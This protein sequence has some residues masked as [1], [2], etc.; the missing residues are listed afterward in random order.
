MSFLSR[1]FGRPKNNPS[2]ESPN[3]ALNSYFTPQPNDAVWSVVTLENAFI[4]QSGFLAIWQR[5]GLEERKNTN[6]LSEDV[7]KKVC[8]AA[9][10]V[11]EKNNTNPFAMILLAHQYIDAD[12][13][14]RQVRRSRWVAEMV[15]RPDYAPPPESYLQYIKNTYFS[16][17]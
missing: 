6:F 3:S 13:L 10:E 16:G 2:F 15:N 17:K 12:P 1:L 4:L 7:T 9:N 14:I 5:A 11:G 8:D